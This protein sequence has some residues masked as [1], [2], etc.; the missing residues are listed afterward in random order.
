[1]I[2]H[3]LATAPGRFSGLCRLETV[4]AEKI[5]ENFAALLVK[6]TGEERRVV[7]PEIWSAARLRCQGLS[8]LPSPNINKASRCVLKY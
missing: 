7:A 3:L 6:I 5:D 2:E 8:V 4:E 1:M